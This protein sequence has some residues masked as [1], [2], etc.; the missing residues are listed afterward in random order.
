M[1]P[2]KEV[3]VLR[4]Q[5]GTPAPGTAEAADARGRVPRAVPGP[6][7]EYPCCTSPH[8]PRFGRRRGPGQGPSGSRA[9]GPRPQGLPSGGRPRGL[10]ETAPGASHQLSTLGLS[11][12]PATSRSPRHQGSPALCSG[13]LG[14]VRSGP[15][16]FFKEN[17]IVLSSSRLPLTRL[18]APASRCASFPE[19]PR[20][21]RG[22]EKQK[23]S[24]G[25]QRLAGP[26]GAQ[27][28]ILPCSWRPW[29]PMRRLGA[30]SPALASRNPR[31]PAGKPLWANRVLPGAANL[32]VRLQELGPRGL[33]RPSLEAGR[34]P[35][36]L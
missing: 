5:R 25:R 33:P 20:I 18:P 23:L 35:R 31:C 2:G 27:G 14:R 36:I 8:P 10:E 6:G 17:T 28:T 19:A 24:L 34:D 3:P 30:A 7:R 29:G 4:K 26:E 12:Q 15:L 13:A 11:K 22:K 32:Q 16:E 1:H 9:W 21:A